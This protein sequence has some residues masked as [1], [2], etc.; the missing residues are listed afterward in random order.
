MHETF[1][2]R[3]RLDEEI[4]MTE[5]LCAF[6]QR[7]F[8]ILLII[9]GSILA[10]LLYSKTTPASFSLQAKFVPSF[11]HH[12]ISSEVVAGYV[13]NAT[14][15]I[16]KKAET[17][18]V[19]DINFRQK[20]RMLTIV[21]DSEEVVKQAYDLLSH[22]ILLEMSETFANNIE[23]SKAV[24]EKVRQNVSKEARDR[25]IMWNETILTLIEENGSVG[26]FDEANIVQLTPQPSIITALSTLLGLL[27]AFGYVLAK[28]FIEERN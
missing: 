8:A 27:V 5:L 19:S 15:T 11:Y 18:K 7:R 9:F 21:G 4:N 17:Y 16:S 28:L 1:G 12:H 23:V 22:R 25:A 20:T 26:A 13:F 10:G 3:F 2:R 14:E 6:W 24:V